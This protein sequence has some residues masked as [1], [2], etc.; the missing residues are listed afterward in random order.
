[1]VGVYDIRINVQFSCSSAPSLNVNTHTHT[2]NKT[3]QKHENLF[4]TSHAQRHG[5][6]VNLKCMIQR[7]EGYEQNCL[8][9]RE[10]C[11]NTKALSLH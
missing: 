6:L 10:R 4:A 8:Y 7:V 2:H 3:L 5:E 1:M 9:M 11:S